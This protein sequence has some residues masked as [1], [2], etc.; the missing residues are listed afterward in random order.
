MKACSRS[1]QADK[2]NQ[3]FL[4]MR[5]H[6]KPSKDLVLMEGLAP[7]ASFETDRPEFS[8]P[9]LGE[10]AL[11]RCQCSLREFGKFGISDGVYCRGSGLIG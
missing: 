6:I 7:Q 9:Y 1:D 3:M 10:F 2:E 11:D 5:Q 8:F 4:S